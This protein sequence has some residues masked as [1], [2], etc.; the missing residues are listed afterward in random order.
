MVITCFAFLD[1][2]FGCSVDL[3]LV[4][5]LA[6]AEASLKAGPF[7]AFPCKEPS[8][9]GSGI[10]LIW[11]WSLLVWHF[12]IFG[13]DVACVDLL[14][15]QCKCKCRSLLESRTFP[16]K[17]ASALTSELVV[18]VVVDVVVVVVV[19]VIPCI[20]YSLASWTTTVRG[21]ASECVAHW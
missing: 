5:T 21:V 10:V 8:T 19:E 15:V 3:L 1:L 11:R 9:F 16:G 13:L 2:L 18:V 4:I 14:L 12:L 7:L 20:S 17:E 6:S